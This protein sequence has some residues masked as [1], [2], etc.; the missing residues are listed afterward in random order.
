M[1]TS[2]LLLDKF[3]AGFL[4]RG[5]RFSFFCI[6]SLSFGGCAITAIRPVQEMSNT[7]AALRAAKE[8]QADILAPE[9][10]RQANEWYLNANREYRLKNFKEAGEYS[11]KARRLAEQAEFLAIRNG[12]A[13]NIKLPSPPGSGSPAVQQPQATS[14]MNSGPQGI[15]VESYSDPKP[16]TNSDPSLNE[17]E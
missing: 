12:G 17:E 14:P 9:L 6:L 7:T 2:S 10:Y 13:R 11:T 16:V 8:V 15:Y 3:K 1:R 5:A 4:N